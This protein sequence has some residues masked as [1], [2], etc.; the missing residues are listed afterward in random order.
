MV[1]Y[2]AG[3][4]DE[5]DTGTGATS[6]SGCEILLKMLKIEIVP[7]SAEVTVWWCAYAVPSLEAFRSAG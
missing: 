1:I 4:V 5:L 6:Y 3:F 2:W 7:N